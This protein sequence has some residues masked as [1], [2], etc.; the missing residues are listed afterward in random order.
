MVESG[1]FSNAEFLPIYPQYELQIGQI[2]RSCNYR[3]TLIAYF[4]LS[5]V[6]GAHCMA[7]LWADF[8]LGLEVL[9]E[10]FFGS[11]HFVRGYH[12]D[13]QPSCYLCSLVLDISKTIEEAYN[14]NR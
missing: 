4:V 10:N 8:G 13:S 1:R 5:S 6:I 14:N 3:P 11:W 2:E 9:A 7:A 12:G